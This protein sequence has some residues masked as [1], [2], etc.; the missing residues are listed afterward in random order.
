MV[1]S[2]RF[3]SWCIYVVPVNALHFASYSPDMVALA[4]HTARSVWASVT[5]IINQDF[6]PG[7]PAQG[8]RAVIN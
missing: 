2:P 5:C 1:R 7:T 3:V 4:T 8:L 6:Y